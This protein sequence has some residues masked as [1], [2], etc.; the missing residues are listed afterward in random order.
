MSHN[1]RLLVDS[2]DKN[3]EKYV[4]QKE[5]TLIPYIKDCEYQ[6]KI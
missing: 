5:N 3:K 1:G 2:F 4:W 6:M